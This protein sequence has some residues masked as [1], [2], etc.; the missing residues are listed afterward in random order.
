MVKTIHRCLFVFFPSGLFRFGCF[1]KVRAAVLGAG[2]QQENKPQEPEIHFCV[3]IYTPDSP[4]KEPR[5]IP[6]TSNVFSN[7]PACIDC[8]G[9]HTDPRAGEEQHA[10]RRAR[11]LRGPGHRSQDV[12]HAAHRRQP[13]RG[14]QGVGQGRAH[15]RL[16]GARGTCGGSGLVL[17]SIAVVVGATLAHRVH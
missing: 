16:V 3:P 11:Q 9:Q 1:K 4:P 14:A 12:L 8:E 15:R 2:M 6:E 10:T 13:F 17:F 7:P 5:L